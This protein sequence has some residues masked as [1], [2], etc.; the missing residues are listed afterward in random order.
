MASVDVTEIEVRQCPAGEPRAGEPITSQDQ[1]RPRRYLALLSRAGDAA[2]AEEGALRAAALALDALDEH[3]RALAGSTE[4]A[5]AL[6]AEADSLRTRFDQRNDAA[7]GQPD[8]MAELWSVVHADLPADQRL[9]LLLHADEALRLGLRDVAAAAS[10]A[11]PSEAVPL[12]EARVRAR[13]QRDWSRSDLLRDQLLALGV[14]ALDG[15]DGST[16]RRRQ[17]AG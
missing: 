16:Y 14:E 1:H 17:A 3:L 12:I 9:A 8:A 10:S 11:L 5:A 15:R 2:E 13:T 4:P 6:S 7:G